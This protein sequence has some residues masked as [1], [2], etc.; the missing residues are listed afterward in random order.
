MIASPSSGQGYAAAKPTGAVYCYGTV[1]YHGGANA[2]GN[3]AHPT[4]ADLGAGDTI[5]GI[6][7]CETVQ[8]ALAPKE[9]TALATAALHNGKLTTTAEAV[10]TSVG[11]TL[12]TT[13]TGY[14]LYAASGAVFAYGAAQYLGGPN[15]STPA[16]NEGK[17]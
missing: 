14:W 8:L 16:P 13:V 3:P 11:A 1:G 10:L 4:H 7:L 6:A 9:G 5:V 17:R 15:A 2:G 12:T